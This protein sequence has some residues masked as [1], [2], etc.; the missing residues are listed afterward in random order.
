MIY[1]FMICF[2]ERKAITANAFIFLIYLTYHT[3]VDAEGEGQIFTTL[4]GTALWPRSNYSFD[5]THYSMRKI[6]LFDYILEIKNIS[7]LF[8]KGVLIENKTDFNL[9]Y[10]L[11]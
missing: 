1:V 11:L 5:W 10:K 7:V 3:K 4:L 6:T 2:R 9:T 8:N